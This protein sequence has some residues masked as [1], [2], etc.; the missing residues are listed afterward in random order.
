LPNSAL[1]APRRSDSMSFHEIQGQE[2]DPRRARPPATGS[3]HDGRAP[4][5][6]SAGELRG[7]RFQGPA[8]E[9]RR[10]PIDF[11]KTPARGRSASP[12]GPAADSLRNPLAAGGSTR[13]DA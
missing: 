3:S 1:L 9:L 5:G 4:A 8:T 12:G 2:A 6:T 7:E 10:T 11:A 13:F